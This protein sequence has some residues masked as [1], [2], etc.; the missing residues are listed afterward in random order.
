MDFIIRNPLEQ[1]R[2]CQTFRLSFRVIFEVPGEDLFA[3]SGSK[4]FHQKVT[5][6]ILEFR[7][8]LLKLKL[9]SRNEGARL[10][11]PGNCLSDL[12]KL[13][14]DLGVCH[15]KSTLFYDV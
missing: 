13:G 8:Y 3:A 2:I 7:S 6:L 9:N 15:T 1:Y 10:F 5:N 14:S 12:F 4:E 11:S